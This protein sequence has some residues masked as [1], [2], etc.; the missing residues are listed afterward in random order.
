MKNQR[1][2]T[3]RQFLSSA[4]IPLAGLACSQTALAKSAYAAA[5]LMKHP[6]GYWRLGEKNGPEAADASGNNH[7]GKYLGAPAFGQRG[8]LEGDPDTAVRFAPP[9]SSVEIASSAQFSQP[10]S[11]RGL[12]VEVWMRPDA[13][14]FPGESSDPYSPYF[15]DQWN[16]W[17][18]GT[19][20]AFPF[21]P[22]AVAA[23][24]RHTLR[25]LP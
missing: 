17:Y 23:Q 13:L 24:T 2:L 9:S 15:R 16:D 10:S 14:V 3:R 18:N 7:H 4:S 22:Q 20:F 1:E 11:G 8:A 12:T 25:L 19:T 6:V 21:T 5:V